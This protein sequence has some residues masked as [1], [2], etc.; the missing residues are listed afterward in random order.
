MPYRVEVSAQAN[1]DLDRIYRT[2]EAATSDKAADWFNGLHIALRSLSE[3]P[4]RSPATRE[5]PLLRH[6]PYGNKPHIYR[7]IYYVNEERGTVTILA[8]RHGARRA[9]KPRDIKPPNT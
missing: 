5:N 2:I 9:F 6:L 8:I 3:M 4:M 1:R 7:A